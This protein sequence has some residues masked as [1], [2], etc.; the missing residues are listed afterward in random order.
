MKNMVNDEIGCE[1]QTFVNTMSLNATQM[2]WP[3]R[4][5]AWR[6]PQLHL[7]GGE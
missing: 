5:R 1:L 4:Q 6:L 3:V 2:F 7:A